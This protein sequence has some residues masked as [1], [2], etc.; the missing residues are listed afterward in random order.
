MNTMKVFDT[1]I[2]L[3]E[4]IFTIAAL[5]TLTPWVSPAAALTLGL[6]I[7][8]FV[9][10]PFLHL[11]HRAVHLLLQC[12][13]VGLGFG[14]DAGNALQ[15]GKEGFLFALA[16]IAG[17][18]VVGWLLG[19]LLNIEKKTSLL[20]AGGTAICG[21][22][23]IAALSP[24]IGADERQVSV[25]IG[26]VFILNSVAL[27]LFP[28]VGGWLHLSQTQFGLWAAIAIHDTSSVVGAAAKYGPEALQVATTVKLAR[29]LWIIP[30]SLLAAMAFR[31]GRV[32][33]KV[34][35]FIGLFIAAVL[36]NSLLPMPVLSL[37]LVKASHAGM[38][39]TLF[40][41]GSGLSRQVLTGTGVRPLVQGI[42]VWVLVAAAALWAVCALVY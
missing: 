6:V 9:G 39:L 24:V 12:S 11:N 41:I 7:A 28:V 38:S 29:A 30:V 3:R 10:H 1:H 37:G 4:L 31:R 35:Y 16:S 23:A 27:F 20:I 22:S 36:L 2:T 19:R 33:V 26:T 32:K 17:T 42:V 21:G 34:P 13:V 8:L 40:L 25:A 5:F 18:L 14:M 15:A